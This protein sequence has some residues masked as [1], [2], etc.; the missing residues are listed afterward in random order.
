MDSWQGV[1]LQNVTQGST[2]VTA[3]LFAYVAYS[4]TVKFE[5]VLSSQTL[6]NLYQVT[7]GHIPVGSTL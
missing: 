4:S 6:V 5:A 1:V 3:S 2:V 7:R